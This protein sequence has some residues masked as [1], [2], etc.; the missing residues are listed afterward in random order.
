M[1]R[2]LGQ[3]MTEFAAGAA[4]LGL[5]LLGCVSVAGLQEAQRRGIVAAR[6]AAFQQSWMRQRHGIEPLRESL[7]RNHFDDSGLLNATGTARLLQ[8]ADVELS[9][10]EGIVPGRSAGAVDFLLAPLRTTAGFMGTGF[11]LDSNGFQSGIVRATLRGADKMPDPFRTL[12][13]RFD[14]PYALLADDWSAAGPSHVARRAG[15]LVPTHLLSPLSSLWRPLSA[16]LSIVEPSLR[17][18]CFGL[19]EPDRIPEDRLGPGPAQRSPACP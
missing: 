5:L 7:A 16:P 9:A 2:Q 4:A 15:G 1:K 14:Q 3:S 18:L 19:L 8:A 13:P 12:Q 10:Q 17:Q 11:D 6:E